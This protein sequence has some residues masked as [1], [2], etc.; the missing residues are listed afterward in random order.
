M[1]ETQTSVLGL[2]VFGTLIEIGSWHLPFA[3]LR[4]KMLPQKMDLFQRLAMTEMALSEID[5]KIE[6][7]APSGT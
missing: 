1:T 4:R 2:G 6:A 7:G 5:I 3:H